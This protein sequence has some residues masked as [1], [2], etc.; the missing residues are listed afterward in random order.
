MWFESGKRFRLTSHRQK[1][2]CS[3]ELTSEARS[4][5]NDSYKNSLK[6]NTLLPKVGSSKLILVVGVKSQ[7]SIRDGNI[8]AG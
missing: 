1:L 3:C 2:L 8:L 7:G 5:G 4:L 6:A